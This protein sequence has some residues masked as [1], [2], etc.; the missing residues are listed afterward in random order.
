MFVDEAHLFESSPRGD[1]L[2]WL[3][4]DFGAFEARPSERM[5]LYRAS[6]C[7]QRVRRS[8]ISRIVHG[9]SEK[10]VLHCEFTVAG[11]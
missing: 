10:G 9:Y 7:A 5:D 3:L 4:G 11:G 1:Q 2:V 6:K 8:R